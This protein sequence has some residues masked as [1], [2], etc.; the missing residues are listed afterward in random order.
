MTIR[1][2]RDLVDADTILWIETAEEKYLEFGEAGRLSYKFD[3]YDIRRMLVQYYPS[4]HAHGITV[5][6]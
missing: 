1:E 3:S 5:Q 6:V 2:L 4:L